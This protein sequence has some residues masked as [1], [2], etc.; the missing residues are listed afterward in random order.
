MKMK[1][2]WIVVGIVSMG[3][4]VGLSVGA[5]RAGAQGPAG[6]GAGAKTIKTSADSAHS[7]HSLNPVKWV[8]KNPKAS[9]SKADAQNDL[10]KRLTAGLQGQGVLPANTNLQDACAGFKE[11]GHC[12][13]GLHVSHNL[14]IPWNCMKWDLTGVQTGADMSMC[15]GPENAKAWSLG[16]SI[17]ALKPAANS[18]AEEKFA[19]KQAH[20][21]LKGAGA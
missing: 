19:V 5:S 10:Y 14:A 11:L 2:K 8:K 12:M 1:N 21:E 13:A 9:T 17:H 18:K 6:A 3:A 16:K 15:K 20:D 7:G 4:T